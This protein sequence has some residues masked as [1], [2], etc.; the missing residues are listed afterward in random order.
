M[1]SVWHV[2]GTTH[3]MQT[4]KAAI[5]DTALN[6]TAFTVSPLVVKT[7]KYSPESIQSPNFPPLFSRNKLPSR[8]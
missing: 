7:A 6:A 2:T 1:P 4:S 5:L 3:G 8:M